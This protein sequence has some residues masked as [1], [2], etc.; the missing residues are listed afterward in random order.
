MRALTYARTV[1]KQA[2]PS[3]SLFS[4]FNNKFHKL[5]LSKY[6]GQILL[7]HNYVLTEQTP[8]AKV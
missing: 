1:L 8:V 2:F 3:T 5:E 4:Q 7:T 6:E